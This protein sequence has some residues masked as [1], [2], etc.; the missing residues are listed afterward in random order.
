MEAARVSK[1]GQ[2]VRYEAAKP[3][4]D[5][6]EVMVTFPSI[7][8]AD[9]PALITAVV[10]SATLGNKGGQIVGIDEK[11][12]VK[13]LYELNGIE[14]GEEIAEEQ[15]PSTGPD[16]YD[17]NRT[18]EDAAAIKAAIPT[19]PVPVQPGPEAPGG[20]PQ[21]QAVAAPQKAAEALVR[22]LLEAARRLKDRA[23]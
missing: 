20:H 22:R 15:Y 11:E 1:K 18:K 7:R 9:N 21:Q 12:M 14:D 13:K 23:A 8:E 2:T 3:S 4:D 17:P 10:E 16:K 6:I 19:A 5:K